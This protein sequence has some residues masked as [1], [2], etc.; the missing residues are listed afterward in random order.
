MTVAITPLEKVGAAEA[1]SHFALA[2]RAL[3]GV[4]LGLG[5]GAFAAHRLHVRLADVVRF[6]QSVPIWAV[7]LSILSTFVM[8]A[9]QALRWHLVMKP[10]VGLRYG[11]A[12]RAQLVG[13]LFNAF[14]P[15]RGGDFLRVQYLGRRTGKSRAAILGT[16]VVDRWLDAWGWLPVIVVL[17][18]G[19]GL[20]GWIVKPIAIFG[21]AVAAWAVVMLVLTRRGFSPRPGSRTG[22]VYAAVRSGLSVFRSS[23]IGFVAFGVAPLPWLWEAVVLREVAGAFAI[24]LTLTRAFCLLIALNVAMLVPSP[25]AVGTLEAG[26][27]AALAFFGIDHSRALAFLVV[28]HLT[29]LIP[30]IVAGAVVLVSE[31]DKLF[32]TGNPDRATPNPPEAAA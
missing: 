30:G 20:P 14:L 11:Q 9:L 13:M 8:F 4:V 1:P 17:G 2:V 25:G 15:A 28:Y 6:A 12:Y 24:P 5:F 26:G 27:M 7:A 16:E 31:G 29:Q 19:G 10:L 22:A 18:L 23:R 32:Q 21:G 3:G